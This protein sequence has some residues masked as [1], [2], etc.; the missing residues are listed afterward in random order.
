M[1]S[2]QGSL[3]CTSPYIMYL[4]TWHCILADSPVGVLSTRRA[5]PQLRTKAEAEGTG[6]TDVA[7][8]QATS[9]FPPHSINAGISVRR[10]N[11]MM[12][13]SQTWAAEI[14]ILRWAVTCVTWWTLGETSSVKEKSGELASLHPFSNFYKA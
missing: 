14:C 10:V 13:M 4:T 1:L 7:Y 9:P 8:E 12:R 11:I 5:P 3:V 6:L 2:A